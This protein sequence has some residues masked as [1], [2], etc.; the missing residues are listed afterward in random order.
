M[1]V[2]G[3]HSNHTRKKLAAICSFEAYQRINQWHSTRHN[4][5]GLA[6]DNIYTKTTD[7]QYLSKWLE[8]FIV[9]WIND[10]KPEWKALKVDNR[11]KAVFNRVVGGK[12]HGEVVGIMGYRKDA[13]Q[14]TG[15]PDIRVL[16]PGMMPLYFEVK[17]GNDRLSEEQK[18]F[19]DSGFGECYVVKTVD[20]FLE[21]WD[22]LC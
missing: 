22:S 13:A 20:G 17:I 5:R 8:R 4:G 18:A 10:H 16:R 14:L 21:V 12:R 11:G 9:R 7:R 3:S 6:V 15:E 1:I 19:I 2:M